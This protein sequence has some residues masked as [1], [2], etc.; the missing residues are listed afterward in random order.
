[1]GGGTNQMFLPVAPPLSCV[2][3]P[4]RWAALTP[5]SR[6][7]GPMFGPATSPEL[8]QSFGE[9]GVRSPT[10]SAGREGA[11]SPAQVQYLPLPMY[12]MQGERNGHTD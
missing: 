1:M 10:L 9:R 8:N 6:P 7:A 11:T 3:S 5:R 12:G 2:T 4:T